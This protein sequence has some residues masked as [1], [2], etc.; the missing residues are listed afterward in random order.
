M[1]P[2]THCFPPR[3]STYLPGSVSIEFPFAFIGK[4]TQSSPRARASLVVL[5]RRSPATHPR[6]WRSPQGSKGN[7]TRCS[8]PGSRC[9]ACGSGGKCVRPRIADTVIV[10]GG[11]S[12]A[13]SLSATKPRSAKPVCKIVPRESATIT[14]PNRGCPVSA[15]KRRPRNRAAFLSPMYARALR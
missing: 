9:K 10:W 15:L 2:N 5:L 7:S 6:A 13:N 12:I 8:R 14:R 1:V 3:V 11:T 4:A